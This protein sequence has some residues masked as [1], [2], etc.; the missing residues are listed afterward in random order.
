V[1]TL[2]D[3]PTGDASPEGLDA[4]S[5]D[6]EVQPAG[7]AYVQSGYVDGTEGTPYVIDSAGYKYELI[8]AEVPTYIGYGSTTAPLVP[9]AWMDFFEDK[10]KLSTNAARRVP[11]DAP[12]ADSSA[13][14]S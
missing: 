1:V 3:E 6:V 10:V 5:H 12:E 4:D 14:E 13:D 7:G 11:E 9:S 8:G 2:A